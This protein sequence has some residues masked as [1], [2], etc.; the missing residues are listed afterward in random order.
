MQDLLH[1]KVSDAMNGRNICV[2][3]QL[4]L[5][6]NMVELHRLRSEIILAVSE[7]T[8]LQ[9]IYLSQCEFIN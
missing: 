1:G 7:C 9:T 6:C 4:K 8:I 5:Y 3:S 2:P